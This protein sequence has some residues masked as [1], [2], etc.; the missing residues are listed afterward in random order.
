MLSTIALFTIESSLKLAKE[1]YQHYQH[2]QAK[3][4]AD[5]YTQLA[6]VAVQNNSQTIEFN[7]TDD[8]N[9]TQTITTQKLTQCIRDIN[10]KKEHLF[11]TFQVRV[12]L[13][14]IAHDKANLESCILKNQSR[15]WSTTNQTYATPITIIIDTYVEYKDT[16]LY[17]TLPNKQI[18]WVT[19]HQRTVEHL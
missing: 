16:T 14:Y 17:P 7:L 5:S 11:D 8:T 12:R 15:I 6:I 2:E 4:L 13:H 1:T 19:Y 3:L 10:A 9:T 18:P